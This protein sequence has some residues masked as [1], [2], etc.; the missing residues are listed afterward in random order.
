MIVFDLE[1]RSG[2]HRFEG[3]FGSSEDYA[4]QQER[5]LVTCPQCASSEIV[6]APMA[7][8]IERKGNQTSTRGAVVRPQEMPTALPVPVAKGSM[9]AEA[10]KMMK[11][12]ATM[13]AQAL[14]KSR[15]VGDDFV[16]T[17]REMHYGERAAEPI[18]GQ[19][20]IQQA[21][22]LFDEGIEVS[23]LPFPVAPPGEAN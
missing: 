11:T 15:W 20:T 3:W 2:G 23:P 5:G 1:C 6:K 19:A 21:R 10:L 12:L 13:Q 8:N 22:E 7:P 16:E 18:H 9:P 4:R 17:S 14:E